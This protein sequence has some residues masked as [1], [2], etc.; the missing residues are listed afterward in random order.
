MAFAP[1]VLAQP[2]CGTGEASPQVCPR[3]QPLPTAGAQEVLVGPHRASL[4]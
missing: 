2:T 1:D 3:P 4:G